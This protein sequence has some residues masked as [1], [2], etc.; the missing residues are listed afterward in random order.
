MARRPQRLLNVLATC[1]M[2]A[3]MGGCDSVADE[4]PRPAGLPADA[5]WIGGPDGGVFMRLEPPVAAA[6]TY[7]GS[8]YHK[9]GLVWYEGRFTLEPAGGAPFD[10]RDRERIAGWD[11][12]QIVLHDGRALVADV[13]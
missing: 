5:F 4:P 2:L 12:T 11:G 7:S 10:V 3:T 6:P 9:N 1:L 8:I 13:K